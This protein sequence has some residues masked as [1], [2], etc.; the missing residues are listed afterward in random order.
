MTDVEFLNLTDLSYR[1]NI[2]QSQ[3]VTG[4]D[5]QTILGRQGRAFA[6]MTIK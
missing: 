6:E 3:A 2:P 5:V 1:P 4:R